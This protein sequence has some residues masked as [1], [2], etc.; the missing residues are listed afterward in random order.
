MCYTSYGVLLSDS[1]DSVPRLALDSFSAID[2]QS[3]TYSSGG[4][5]NFSHGH[6]TMHRREILQAL[7]DR[8]SNPTYLE[9]GVERG[10]LLLSLKAGR[11]IAVDPRFDISW[12]K[13]LRAALSHR[14]NWGIQY[15]EVPSDE[16]FEK[17]AEAL[18]DGIDVAFVDGLHTHD[19]AYRDVLNCLKHLKPGGFIL[20]HDCIPPNA[21]AAE[22]AYSPEEV[23][24]KNLPD[25]S[26]EWTGDVYKAVIQLRQEN[27]DLN[28][29]TLD[30]DYG[31]AV[32]YRGSQEN[33]LPEHLTEL[34]SL[35]YQDFLGRKREL[36][37]V[38]P[39]EFFHEWLR[40][41]A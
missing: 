15:F 17:N 27:R 12:R 16:F 40:R 3:V 29:F 23:A 14:S 25:W 7:L 2:L 32:V 37:N 4:G 35:S 18:K 34:Q 39:P 6:G 38:K 19:Q 1:S 8:K 9:I 21:A 33:P 30:C 24:A 22:Y 36:L 28:V 41:A 31:V 11:K 20:M 13:K 26:G 5:G 10:K